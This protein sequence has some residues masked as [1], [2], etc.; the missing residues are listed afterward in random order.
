M[1][2]FFDVHTPPA[3]AAVDPS[4]RRFAFTNVSAARINH[5]GS[6]SIIPSILRDS[7]DETQP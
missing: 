6:K 1:L 7:N 5:N 2:T 4:Y 3:A